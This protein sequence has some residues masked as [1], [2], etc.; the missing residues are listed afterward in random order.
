MIIKKITSFKSNNND[1]QSTLR[2]YLI[3]KVADLP[4]IDV[5][6]IK[7]IASALSTATSNTEQINQQAAVIYN[8]KKLCKKKSN[9]I[10][11]LFYSFLHS[12]TI[13]SI[14]I[15]RECFSGIINQLDVKTSQNCSLLIIELY[16][17]VLKSEEQ[18]LGF[19]KLNV[20]DLIVAAD[21][22]ISHFYT[23]SLSINGN[24]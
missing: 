23:I 2:E 6:G 9:P 14:L 17:K 3:K 21:K 19:L 11:F 1:D 20:S 15:G 13:S 12:Q 18:D 4:I 8:L 16:N 7:V 24:F 10:L 22:L 5:S